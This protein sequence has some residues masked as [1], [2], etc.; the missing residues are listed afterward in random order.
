VLTENEGKRTF[1]RLHKM[2]FDL[3]ILHRQWDFRWAVA[4]VGGQMS[5]I[6]TFAQVK[7]L[8]I[9]IYYIQTLLKVVALLNLSI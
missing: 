3:N 1:F 5:E 2:C 6:N 8:S 4:T 7:K 9:M